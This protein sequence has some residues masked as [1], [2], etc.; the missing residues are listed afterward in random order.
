MYWS[1]ANKRLKNHRRICGAGAVLLWI[2]PGVLLVGAA[3]KSSAL[4]FAGWMSLVAGWA[5]IFL[6]STT[7]RHFL[8][9]ASIPLGLAVLLL[10]SQGDSPI[11]SI[12]LLFAAMAL[13]TVG[14]YVPDPPPGP[15]FCARCG[16]NLR[17][18]PQPRC[19]ECA[20]PFDPE[21]LV[22]TLESDAP[23]SR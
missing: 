18:L 17:G 9:G 21:T 16:Y 23:N 15:G 3:A 2:S 20:T 14:A 12:I 10:P 6:W 8:L 22:S 5:C 4:V 1:P 13:T 11:P 19:P 7:R